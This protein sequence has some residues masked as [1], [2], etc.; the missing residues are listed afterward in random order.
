MYDQYYIICY[1]NIVNNYINHGL[2]RYR[3]TTG[4]VDAMQVLH[5]YEY[6]RKLKCMQRVL[7]SVLRSAG[8]NAVDGPHT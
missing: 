7:V 4:G 1:N 2:D 6:Q 8:I 5:A 3:R